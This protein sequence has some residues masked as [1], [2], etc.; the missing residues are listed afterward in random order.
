[1][2]RLDSRVD[3]FP[4]VLGSCGEGLVEVEIG[5]GLIWFVNCGAVAANHEGSYQLR[6]IAR[7]NEEAGEMS[8]ALVCNRC[9]QREILH[10]R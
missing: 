2:K 5:A 7:M 9:S 4:A 3:I 6:L 10:V 8:S 1:M